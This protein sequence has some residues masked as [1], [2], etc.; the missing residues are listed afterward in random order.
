M[1]TESSILVYV[2]FKAP[3]V[4]HTDASGEV[5]GAAMYQVHGGKIGIIAY[6]SRN[7][8]KNKRKYQVN[9]LEF[10]ALK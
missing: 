10:L 6:A 8:S 1:C 4:L 9:N 5:L 3:L 7:L 2:D